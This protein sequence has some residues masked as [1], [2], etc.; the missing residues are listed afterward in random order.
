[1]NF[2]G[3]PILLK[4][5]GILRFCMAGMACNVLAFAFIPGFGAM[6]RAVRTGAVLWTGVAL[7]IVIVDLGG[8]IWP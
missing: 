6:L 3:F 8:M 7:L 4:R 2:F 5:F 1:M